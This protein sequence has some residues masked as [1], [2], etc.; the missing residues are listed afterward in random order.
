ML[1]GCGCSVVERLADSLPLRFLVLSCL[2]KKIQ[3]D[4][5]SKVLMLSS[6]N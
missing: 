3:A 6:A 1:R 2:R 4:K 5:D